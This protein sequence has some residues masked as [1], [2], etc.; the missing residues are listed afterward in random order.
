MIKPKE[1]LTRDRPRQSIKIRSLDLFRICIILK[2]S[3]FEKA[4]FSGQQNLKDVLKSAYLN[5]SPR[6]VRKYAWIL[7]ALSVPTSE[8]FSESVAPAPT[9]ELQGREFSRTNMRAYFRAKC[10][11]VFIRL[12]IFQATP[13]L[14][15]IEEY[16]WDVP[17][18]QPEIFRHVTCLDQSRA[19]ENIWWIIRE[20]KIPRWGFWTERELN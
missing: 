1:M 4:W 5:N 2:E 17:L 8:Q 20:V 10:K 14:L 7:R 12:E 15:K 3:D 11:L 9:C 13:A 6:L 16:H 18:F 19:S